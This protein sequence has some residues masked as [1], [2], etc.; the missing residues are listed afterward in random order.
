MASVNVWS[1]ALC[2]FLTGCLRLR[3]WWNH[4][5]DTTSVTAAHNLCEKWLTFSNFA[6]DND[7]LCQGCYNFGFLRSHFQVRI[8]C[9]VT[10]GSFCSLQTVL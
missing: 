4:C 3:V 2:I 5:R 7:V 6:Y 9:H 1:I 10:Q 8:F